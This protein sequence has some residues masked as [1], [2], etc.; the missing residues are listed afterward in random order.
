MDDVGIQYL[1]VATG[2]SHQREAVVCYTLEDEGLDLL[3]VLM[4]TDRP[5]LG[6]TAAPERGRGRVGLKLCVGAR[7]GIAVTDCSRRSARP[8][9]PLF[10]AAL[11]APMS[12]REFSAGLT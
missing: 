10:Y 6:N 5:S 12:R 1:T 7:P 8:G 2:E 3:V 4:V 9:R 11:I